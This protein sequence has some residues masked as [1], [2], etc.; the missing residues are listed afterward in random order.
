[1]VQSA[2]S[3]HSSAGI[4][5]KDF[6]KLIH[7]NTQIAGC[8]WETV[9]HEK[10]CK[11]VWKAAKKVHFDVLKWALQPMN[12]NEDRWIYP[13]TRIDARTLRTDNEGWNLLHYV[14]ANND[15]NIQQLLSTF[16]LLIL[17]AGCSVNARDYRGETPFHHVCG[18]HVKRD[19]KGRR[20]YIRLLRLLIEHGAD[21]NEPVQV[22]F[23]NTF[24]MYFFFNEKVYLFIFLNSF[25]CDALFLIIKQTVKR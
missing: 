8:V 23:S 13:R 21:V 25:S 10:K 6:R 4:A 17:W 19:W 5:Y 3:L 16:R 7:K 11:I 2:A 15:E 22:S 14:C 20:L 9:A 18:S 12:E 24:N 1:M